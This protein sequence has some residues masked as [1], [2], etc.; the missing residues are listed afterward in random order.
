VNELEYFNNELPA[1]VWRDKYTDEG[2]QNP[3]DMHRRLAR[4]L[5]GPLSEEEVYNLLKDFKFIIPQGSVMATLGTEKIASLSNCLVVGQPEDSYGGIMRKD[6][7]LVQ[8]M[9]RRMGVGI[10][11]SSLRPAGSDVNNAA[12]TSTG[13]VSFMHRYSN[14]TRE[15][16]QDGR[17]GALM[18]SMDIRHPDVFEFVK[19]KQDLAKVTGANVSVM[20][21]DDFMKAVEEDKDYY[22]RW[23]CD[24]DIDKY[25]K[26]LPKEYL[27]EEHL[28]YNKIQTLLEES[29]NVYFTRIKAKEL[30]DLII[31]CA[32]NSAEPGV[33][34]LDRHWNYSPDSVYSQYKGVTTNPCGEIFMQMYDACRLICV[35]LF[36]F[37]KN[38]F[39]DD[40][41]F[42][43]ELFYDICYKQQLLA[44]RIVDLE[45]EYI[46]RIIEKVEQSGGE[47]HVE[48]DLWKNILKVAAS[49]RRTGSGLTALGDCF[50][51][52][53]LGYD[54]DE[55]KA[56]LR[57]IMKTKFGAELQCSVDLAIK[58]GHFE[59]WN[60][61]LEFDIIGKKNGFS[62]VGKNPFYQMIAEEFPELAFKMCVFGRRNVSF[63]T[64]A[65]TGSV[66]YLR[67]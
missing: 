13:A 63:S 56:R 40:A 32:W 15:V 52:L 59:G 60:P 21:R 20:V 58:H 51:A 67:L 34:F 14:T 46:K 27:S 42:D 5:A 33:L 62:V 31:E 66:K 2:E 22:L 17:R 50:A 12:Q 57:Q 9:K 49:G 18:I 3:D 37:V 39:K 53:G 24:Y 41:F 36:S 29:N 23:P 4:E 25:I 19:M 64:V 1:S 43:F 7:Q 35:N 28:P 16:A 38:P 65:P 47:N 11:I 10:D 48:L 26:D 8:A 61:D 44:D 6:E 30:W 45:L 55:A 54:N